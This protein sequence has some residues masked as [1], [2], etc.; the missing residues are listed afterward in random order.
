LNR[1]NYY[2]NTTYSSV[3]WPHCYECTLGESD[4]E[5]VMTDPLG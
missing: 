5:I 2:Y 1:N 3:Q 4:G